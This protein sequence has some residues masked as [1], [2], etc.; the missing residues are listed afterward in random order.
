M[1]CKNCGLVLKEEDQFCRR[2]GFP[3]SNS[4]DSAHDTRSEDMQEAETW[5]Q[6]SFPEG[7]NDPK[8]DEKNAN[9]K[10]DEPVELSWKM[11]FTG[12]FKRHSKE[13]AEEIFICGT[14]KTTPPASEASKDWPRPWLYA[15]VFFLFA[16]AFSLLW[17]CCTSLKDSDAMSGLIVVGAFMASLSTLILF[18]EANAWRDVSFYEVVKIFLVGGCASLLT[19]IILYSLFGIN[20]SNFIGA[21]MAGFFEECWKALVIYFFIKRLKNVRILNGMLIAACVGA[22][23]AA[24][25]SSGYAFRILMNEE[26]DGMMNAIFLRGVLTPAGHVAWAAI[27]GAAIVYAA[28]SKKER[29]SIELLASPQFLRLF[30]IPVSLHMIWCSPLSKIASDIY[31]APIILTIFVWVVVLIFTDIGLTEVSRKP[32]KAE[33]NNFKRVYRQDN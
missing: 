29:M 2:C 22:G 4:S 15:R 23:F 17:I 24:F 19:T 20:E 33:D 27:T 9:W 7:D 31:L 5:H 11:L 13:E 21:I 1:Y 30:A 10:S 32:E 16:L 26:W 12:I 8:H 18:V 14:K 6:R 25:E 28:R 3:V